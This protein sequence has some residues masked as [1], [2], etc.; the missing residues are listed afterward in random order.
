MDQKNEANKM[1]IIMASC[2]VCL[3]VIWQ[4]SGNE[5]F[6]WLAETIA[7]LIPLKVKLPCLKSLFRQIILR[8]LYV[9]LSYLSKELLVF[10]QVKLFESLPVNFCLFSCLLQSNFQTLAGILFFDKITIQFLHCL[11]LRVNTG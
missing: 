10:S 4:A 5:S 6:N 3:P 1:F 9:L 2:P 8:A 7:R 11:S